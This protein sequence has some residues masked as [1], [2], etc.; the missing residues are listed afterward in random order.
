MPADPV[1]APTLAAI[2]PLRLEGLPEPPTLLELLP[3]WSLAATAALL[4]L[5][6]AWLLQRWMSRDRSI[7]ADA[8]RAFETLAKRLRLSAADRSA[9]RALAQAAEIEP[10]ALVLSR[11][12]FEWATEHA[13]SSGPDLAALHRR[14]FG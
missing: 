1:L 3:W 13:P 6:I 14:L 7:E 10:A 11:S 12:A 8:R 5:T 4:L 2:A 9:V